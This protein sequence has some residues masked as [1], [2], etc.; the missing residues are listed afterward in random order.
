M[1]ESY[2]YDFSLND[3]VDAILEIDAEKLKQPFDDWIKTNPD[4]SQMH[5]AYLVKRLKQCMQK[6]PDINRTNNKRPR[7]NGKQGGS[8]QKNKKPR[9]KIIES[10]SEDEGQ[11]D[12]ENKGEF[13]S[14]NKGESDSENKGES[15]KK[16]DN[17]PEKKNV[18][19]S[20][21]NG[22][23]YRFKIV[24][25]KEDDM[26]RRFKI[27]ENVK[28]EDIDVK[29]IIETNSFHEEKFN[30]LLQIEDDYE[31]VKDLFQEKNTMQDALAVLRAQKNFD[32]N[33]TKFWVELL[34]DILDLL[35]SLNIKN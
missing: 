13:D 6:V 31:M 2:L 34:I 1:S 28:I 15:E 17:T 12:S 26:K 25:N 32:G 35:S 33:Y 19:T 8:G 29:K 7:Q 5:R 24:R 30:E 4:V 22:D 23:D 27:P 14:E 16:S 9:K 18:E 20:G 21:I 10:D 11:F 3:I